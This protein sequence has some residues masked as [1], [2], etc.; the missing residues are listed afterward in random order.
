MLANHWVVLRFADGS[1]FA[2]FTD[3]NGYLS[4]DAVPTVDARLEL[5]ETMPLE[6]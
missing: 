6:P 3:L 2:G 5:P 1:A 4:L